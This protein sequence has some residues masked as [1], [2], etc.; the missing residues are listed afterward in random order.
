MFRPQRIYNPSSN[1]GSASGS[2]PNEMYPE[3]WTPGTNTSQPTPFWHRGAV[4]LARGNYPNRH[5]VHKH[6]NGR[7][8][9]MF[10]CFSPCLC[11]KTTLKAWVTFV[12]ISINNPIW[13]RP[14]ALQMNKEADFNSSFPF[15]SRLFFTARDWSNTSPWI[16]DESEIHPWPFPAVGY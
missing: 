4:A 13:L 9:G 11:N 6:D 10:R 5:Y 2:P 12:T 8:R 14:V 7:C 15:S 16:R 1:S 3:G